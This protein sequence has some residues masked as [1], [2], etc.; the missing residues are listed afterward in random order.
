MRILIAIY[1]FPPTHY[2]GAEQAAVRIVRWLVENG[3]EVEVFALEALDA[4][5]F[6]VDTRQENGYTIYRVHYNLKSGDPFKNS[7]DS[8]PLGKSLAEILAAGS[9]DLV[10]IVSGYLLGRSVIAAAKTAAVPVVIT[11]TE[12]W[13]MCARLNLLHLN[14]SLCS[15]PE[16]HHK[17][18]R[19]LLEDKRRYRLPA[20]VVPGLAD[21]FWRS[22]DN[23]PFV[24]AKAS[25]VADRQTA[26]REALSQVDLIISPSRFLIQKFSEFGFDMSRSVY[27]RHGLTLPDSFHRSTGSRP[28]Q[29]LRLGYI[30]Q[31][32][33]HKGPD[34]LVEAVMPLLDQ[35]CNIS[36]DLWGPENE[37]SAL[38]PKSSRANS[39]VSGNSV[40]R[41]LRWIKSVGCSGLLRCPGGSLA[42]VRKQPDGDCGG[43][44]CR[45]PGHCDQSGRYGGTGRA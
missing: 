45:S 4:A 17:C 36:V 32:K 37:D 1:G 31:I 18:A 15:G 42:L 23:A 19:C 16:S 27:I 35:Q 8:V 25:A 38:C 10:H 30:G 34:L 39:P 11:L 26:L 5:E 2:T 28:M 22:V 9:F 6:K 24:Q 41:T 20:Q 29:T 12:Y 43:A 44:Y 40:A 13:F 14:G 7:Y 33:S 3:H 21:L